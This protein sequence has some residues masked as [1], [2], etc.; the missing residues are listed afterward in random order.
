MER[1]SSEIFTQKCGP[2]CR[3]SEIGTDRDHSGERNP[4][5]GLSHKRPE[6]LAIERH[7]TRRSCPAQNGSRSTFF[8]IFPDALRGISS[9]KETERGSL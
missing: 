6:A 9:A 5:A 4:P 2:K 7:P 1:E 3:P 8:K